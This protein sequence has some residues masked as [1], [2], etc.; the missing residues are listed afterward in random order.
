MSL[1]LQINSQYL[2]EQLFLEGATLRNVILDIPNRI[3]SDFS[4]HGIGPDLI[5]F[6]LI[7]RKYNY[8]AY[9]D[10][11]LSYF[12][13]HDGSISS[14]SGQSK[15]VLYY[16]L[17]KCYFVTNYYPQIE[18]LFY[19]YIKI[20]ILIFRKWDFGERVTIYDFLKKIKIFHCQFI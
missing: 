8:Y 19:A 10:E 6:L 3:K 13:D 12:R 17:A 5:L 4:A 16:S 20:I 14:S 7:I 9:I 1:F 18:E 2:Q 11:I 15:R